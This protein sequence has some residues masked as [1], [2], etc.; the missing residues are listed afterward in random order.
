MENVMTKTPKSDSLAHLR[1]RFA[2]IAEQAGQAQTMRPDSDNL[3]DLVDSMD[4]DL[5]A[6]IAII[7]RLRRTEA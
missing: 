4:N 7:N 2:V 5:Q 1:Q 3:L 6:V